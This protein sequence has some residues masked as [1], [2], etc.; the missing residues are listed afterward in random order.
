MEIDLLVK[1]GQVVIPFSG[2]VKADVAVKGGK[3]VGINSNRGQEEVKAKTIIDVNGRLV[4]PGWIDS[5]T[6]LGFGSNIESEYESESRSAAVGGVTTMMNYTN[7]S[8]SYSDHFAKEKRVGEQKS[9]IDFGLHFGLMNDIHLKELPKYIEEFGVCSF[10]FFMNFRGEEG[11]YLGVEGIDDGFMFDFFTALA[12]Y[13]GS[14]IVVHAENIEIGWR[15]RDRLI[16]QGRTDLRAWT[17]SKPYFIEVEAVQRALF[18]AEVANCEIYIPH[19]TTKD[20][21]EA[22]RGYKERNKKIHCETCTSYLVL[23]ADTSL[24]NFAKSNP[25]LREQSDV[26]ALWKGLEEGVIDCVSSDHLA[27]KKDKKAGSI[28]KCAAGCPGLATTLPVLLSEGVN[29]GRFGIEKIAEMNYNTAKI[30]NLYPRKG[31]IMPGSDADF[32]IIDLDLEKKVKVEDM[33]SEADWSLYEG[34]NLKGWP[35]MTIVRGEVVMTDGEVRGQ[36]GY[37]VFLNRSLSKR[38]AE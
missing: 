7:C 3:I 28:W 29:K 8:G 37:G 1:N 2:I 12:N 24:G 6:H 34:W 31:T 36:P 21:L 20:S 38:A 15:L 9:V 25:P 23:D 33:K 19:V 14:C 11:K 22:V 10:K 13:P 32:T 27:R 5:H 26:Q 35:V 4:L 30:F 16:A 17:E 18:Y